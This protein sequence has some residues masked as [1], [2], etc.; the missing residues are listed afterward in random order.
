MPWIRKRF[1]VRVEIAEQLV[2]INARH[3]DR[4][5]RAQKRTFVIAHTSRHLCLHPAPNSKPFPLYILRTHR[6]VCNSTLFRCLPYS[7]LDTPGRAARKR[8]N[9][10]S[11]FRQSPH[12][13]TFLASR[14]EGTGFYEASPEGT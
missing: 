2:S 14:N 8:S 1:R 10:F 12:A 6:N 9:S 7:S 5:L 13:F 3:T 11:L 4:R